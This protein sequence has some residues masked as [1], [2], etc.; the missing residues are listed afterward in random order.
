MVRKN[1]ALE[2]PRGRLWEILW[3]LGQSNNCNFRLPKPSKIELW[4][5]L[6]GVFGRSCG[7]LGSLGTSWV[8]LGHALGASAS[9]VGRLGDVL[10]SSW[11]VLGGSWQVL[12]RPWRLPGTILE[13]FL[14]DFLAS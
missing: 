5:G 12:G 1:R 2:R 8:C 14:Q 7:V 9:A 11:C 13:A 3:L 6:G 10:R 4:R